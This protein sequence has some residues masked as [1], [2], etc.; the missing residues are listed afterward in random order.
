MVNNGEKAMK[1][2]LIY[3]ARFI[4][5]SGGAEKVCCEMANEMSRR[6]HEV[7]IVYCYGKSGRPLFPLNRDVKMYNLMA[8]HPEK[9][10][11]VDRLPFPSYWKVIRELLR[12]FSVPKAHGLQEWYVGQ[13]IQNEIREVVNMDQPDVIVSYW[14]KDS[15]ILLNY[16]H[17]QIPFITMFHFSPDILARDASE[18][19]RKACEYSAR[20]QVLLPNDIERLKKYIPKARP[21]WIPNAVPQYEVSARLEGTKSI[22][23]IINMARLDKTTKRQHILIEAFALIADA[24]PK[25]QVELWGDA[26]DRKYRLELEGRIRSHHLENRIFLK[27]LTDHALDKYISAD[28]FAWTS[29]H[30]G[31]GLALAEAMSAGLPAV[32]FRSCTAATDLISPACG[33]LVDDGSKAFAKGLAELMENQEKR[34][35]MGRAAKEEMKSYSASIVWDMWEQVLKETA[36]R[37]S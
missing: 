33:V 27:G 19:S 1:I 25:W 35:V 9:W 29:S 21:I 24:Y 20:V 14:P 23:K 10:E 2:M 18:G 34:I 22:Y 26:W 30:E 16:A 36:K 37:K 12:V 6:G 7:T 11:G 8:L 28:I 5:S 15:N 3:L 17:I 32:A 13:H 4:D 31:F